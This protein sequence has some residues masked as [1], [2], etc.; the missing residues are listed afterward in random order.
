[1]LITSSF[2]LTS[3]YLKNNEAK[4]Q[5]YKHK[6]CGNV[7]LNI[8]WSFLKLKHKSFKHGRLKIWEKGM[9]FCFCIFM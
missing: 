7:T 9:M 6:T 8:S 3:S 1:M 4:K 2:R 5:K